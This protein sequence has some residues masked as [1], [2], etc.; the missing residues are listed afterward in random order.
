MKK[1][2]IEGIIKEVKPGTVSRGVVYDQLVIF[3][4]KNGM[5]LELFDYNMLIS[6]DM[7]NHKKKIQIKLFDSEYPEELRR[8]KITTQEKRIAYEKGYYVYGEVISKKVVK[9][10]STHLE[11][12]VVDF[13]I[14]CATLVTKFREFEIG[15]FICVHAPRLDIVTIFNNDNV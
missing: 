7:V 2:Y 13:G 1:N 8:K 5:N 11:E 10:E 3:E 6:N 4:L 9:N 12:C 14:G 15:D